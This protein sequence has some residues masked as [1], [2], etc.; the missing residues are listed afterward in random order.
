MYS[1]R[2]ALAPSLCSCR[3]TTFMLFFR[4]CVRYQVHFRGFFA[5]EFFLTDFLFGL[6][7]NFS[8]Y[9]INY[10]SMSTQNPNTHIARAIR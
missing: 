1:I 6:A 2:N 5:A 3:H 7:Y 8:Q 10:I 4:V 9:L